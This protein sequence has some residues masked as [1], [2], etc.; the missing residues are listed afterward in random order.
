MD[1]AQE[2]ALP[3]AVPDFAEV[4][5]AFVARLSPEVHG[6]GYAF[7]EIEGES[8]GSAIAKVAENEVPLLVAAL[9][10][11]LDQPYRVVPAFAIDG[12]ELITATEAMFVFW[13]KSDLVPAAAEDVQAVRDRLASD[14]SAAR[15]A[16]SL[17]HAFALHDRAPAVEVWGAAVLN[18]FKVVEGIAATVVIEEPTDA[19]AQRECAVTALRKKLGEGGPL[20]QQTKAIKKARDR[21]AEIDQSF[22]SRRIQAAGRAYQIDAPVTTSALALGR[23][24]NEQLGHA[25]GTPTVEELER[26]LERK[27]PTSAPSIART[28]LRAYIDHLG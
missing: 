7:I 22:I 4:A 13:D 14:P 12:P 17:A 25:G 26:W 16:R 27:S 5:S 24:R 18:Y 8:A 3:S 9:S 23:F 19:D 21:L 20:A 28:F 15:A 10:L 11:G 1:P 6:T 2:P